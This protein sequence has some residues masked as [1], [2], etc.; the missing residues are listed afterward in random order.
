MERFISV[1]LEHYG[2]DLPLWLAPEQVRLVPISD[3]QLD[4]LSE[5]AQTLRQEGLRVEVD[6]RNERMNSKIR[7]AEHEKIPFVAVAGKKEAE[8]K[9]LSIRKRHGENLGEMEI[10]TFAELLKKQICE[11]S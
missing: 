5:V 1:L 4:Y 7:L 8:E 2:G 11:K 9:T 10:S 3:E 6:R